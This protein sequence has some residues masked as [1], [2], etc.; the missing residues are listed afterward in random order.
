VLRRLAEV[1]ADQSECLPVVLERALETLCSVAWLSG[2][3]AGAVFAIREGRPEL[4]ARYGPG[5]SAVAGRGEDRG[6]DRLLVRAARTRTPVFRAGAAGRCACGHAPARGHGRYVVPLIAANELV[7]VLDFHLDAG[8]RRRE[9]DLALIRSAGNL[10][11][12]ALR[13]R[14]HRTGG[15]VDHPA[16][17]AALFAN[18]LEMVLLVDDQGGIAAANPPACEALGHSGEELRGLPAWDLVPNITGRRGLRWWRQVTAR[19]RGPARVRL[20]TRTGEPL[21]VV[22]R[23]VA[24]ALPGMHLVLARDVTGQRRAEDRSDA[25]AG[26]L[27]LLAACI[28]SATATLPEEEALAGAVRAIARTAPLR[29]AWV[30]RPEAPDGAV[31]AEAAADGARAGGLRVVAHAG[32]ALDPAEVERVTRDAADPA[33]T[34]LRTGRT[35]LVRDLRRNRRGRGWRGQPLAAT[36][37]A[38][39]AVPLKAR[40][41]AFAVLVVHARDGRAL[42]AG[43]IASLERAA[44]V[45]A[46]GVDRDRIAGERN[47]LLAASNQSPESIFITTRAGRIVYVNPAFERRT[48]YAR[49][50]ALGQTPRLLKSGLQSPAFYQRLWTTLLAG[51]PFYDIFRNR[52]K[53]GELVYEA[54]YLTPIRDGAGRVSHFISTGR[55]VTEQRRLESELWRMAYQDPLT[56]LPNRRQIQEWADAV[57]QRAE[58]RRLAALLII[59]LNDFKTVNDSL[60]HHVGDAVLVEVGRRFREVLRTSDG[61]VRLGGD[62][63]GVFLDDVS[64][65]RDAQVVAEKLLGALEEPVRVGGRTLYISAAVGIGC[66]PPDGTEFAVLMQNADTAM[67][68]AKRIGGNAFQFYCSE[69][70]SGAVATLDLHSGLHEALD[71]GEFELHYQPFTDVATGTITGMEALIRW[72][73][74]ELGLVAPGEFIP[75]AEQ[76]GLILPIGEWVLQEACRTMRRLRDRGYSDLRMA[77]NLSARQFS[78]LHLPRRIA[79]ILDELGLEGRYLEVEITESAI[80]ESVEAATR[81]TNALHELGVTVALDDFGTGYSSLN[82]LRDFRI[83]H[84]KIDKSFIDGIPGNRG[85][86][87]IARTV[88]AMAHNLGMRAIAEGI[89]THPQLTT[90]RRWRCDESQGFLLSRPLVEA[91]IH[92]LLATGTA[93]PA[94]PAA[95]P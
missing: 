64:D 40:G 17:A 46:C 48:G 3:G 50:E 77:V 39:C 37:R 34:A 18:A 36:A 38:L 33:R 47:L 84:L 57:F 74:P 83:D 91:E 8:S 82:Y 24:G 89:E 59:D 2:N 67:Y 79:A 26:E 70:H 7:G 12:A 69:M 35:C 90:L 81:A 80:M 76:T 29:A 61:L 87:A 60:G 15:P 85:N 10:L 62:E 66:Y 1:L 41:R 21:E 4:V 16:L 52:T 78:Q 49:E 88:V 43:R 31:I 5:A 94:A 71:K 93:L 86:E 65:H 44:A 27:S 45:L 20:R 23:L 92:Q 28:E 30:A 75:L 54:K 13:E 63:F 11:A 95:A 72:R 68:R 56:G 53:S 51:R 9:R 55:D 25:P 73:H 32:D 14:V 58:P 42:G 19:S 22:A 6:D